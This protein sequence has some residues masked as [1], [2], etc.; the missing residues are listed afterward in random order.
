MITTNNNFGIMFDYSKISNNY[1]LI[2]LQNNNW[3]GVDNATNNANILNGAFGSTSM[4]QYITK[5]QFDQL[6]IRIVATINKKTALG[7]INKKPMLKLEC[8]TDTTI[9]FVK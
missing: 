8:G 2:E 9:W 6:A 1:V 7:I 4:H 3:F 5:Q